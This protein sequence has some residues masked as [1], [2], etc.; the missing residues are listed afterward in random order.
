MRPLKSSIAALLV[1]LLA[2][3]CSQV[4]AQESG[5]IAGTVTDVADGKPL[6]FANVLVL[7]TG[8]GTF[9]KE[10]GGFA[11]EGVPVGTY[12]V[13]V[14]MMGYAG[15]TMENIVVR[16]NQTTELSFKLE[17]TVVVR[18]KPVDVTADRPMVDV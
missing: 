9:V 5:R 10:N 18:M 1:I 17:T 16:P 2:F 6:A 8:M 11:I 4:L 13:R 14:M 3:G 7:G 12:S 15:Q